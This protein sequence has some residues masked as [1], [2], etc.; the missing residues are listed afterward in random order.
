MKTHSF[1]AKPG[2]RIDKLIS[3]EIPEISRTYAQKLIAEGLVTIAGSKVNKSV[4]VTEFSEICVTVPPPTTLAVT[5]QSITL[6]IVY[7]DNDLLVI[8]KPRGMVVHPAAGNYKGTLVNALLYHC[9]DSLS[10]INGVIRPGIVHRIDK[11]TT[12]L[13]LVAKNNFAHV[14]LAEQIKNR[15]VTRYYMALV[16][17]NIKEDCGE[18]RTTIGRSPKNRKK[19]AVNVPAGRE[20]ITRFSVL[21]RYIGYTLVEC[22][23]QTGRTHQIRVHMAHLGNSVVGDKLYGISREKFALEGQLLHA[24]SVGFVHPRTKEELEF[25]AELPEDFEKILKILRPRD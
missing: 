1:L 17:G 19:M 18:I 23:L 24:Q 21:K 25:Y 13:L 11:D 12:G 4:T 7:E 8:N 20:A 22:R 3:L 9:G 14:D 16:N 15:T 5:P 6:D 2:T 10:E